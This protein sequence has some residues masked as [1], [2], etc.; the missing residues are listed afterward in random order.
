MGLHLNA[1][2]EVDRQRGREWD[3]ERGQKNTEKAEKEKRNEKEF[4]VSVVVVK[5][6]TVNSGNDRGKSGKTKENEA[7]K[8]K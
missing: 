7:S 2:E 5:L 8:R 3:H 4:A 1:T 6:L